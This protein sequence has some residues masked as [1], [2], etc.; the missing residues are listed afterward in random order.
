MCSLVWRSIP[1][2]WEITRSLAADRTMVNLEKMDTSAAPTPTPTT[3]GSSSV[4]RC[5]RLQGGGDEPDQP[6][7]ESKLPGA[8]QRETADQA[9]EE[10]QNQDDPAAAQPFPPSPEDVT[11]RLPWYMSGMLML[12]TSASV[13][14]T[15]PY[16]PAVKMRESSN[17][18][19]GPHVRPHHDL[20]E[21]QGQRYRG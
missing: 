20:D 5:F 16:S 8:A 1:V 18:L 11:D 14:S 6:K 15:Q 3:P 2:L 12:P 17:P 9:Y 13:S 10:G 7:D 4:V 21:L 19:R